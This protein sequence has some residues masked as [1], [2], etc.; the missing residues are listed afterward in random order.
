MT[1]SELTAW[2]VAAV[3][4]ITALVKLWYDYY[5]KPKIDEEAK[6]AEIEAEKELK[7]AELNRH[8][9]E[10]E[11]LVNHTL[12]AELRKYRRMVITNFQLEQATKCEVYKDL[13]VK[14]ID[15]W[16]ELLFELA[17]KID[18]VCNQECNGECEMV[19]PGV[20]AQWNAEVLD[21]GV[22]RYSTYYNSDEYTDQEKEL[23]AYAV[24]VFNP[25]HRPKI[26][27]VEGA[28][29]MCNEGFAFTKCTKA[30][31]YMIFTVYSSAFVLAFRDMQKVL[32]ASNGK[33]DG[34][35]FRRR[36]YLVAKPSFIIE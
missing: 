30:I 4:I 6:L 5:K 8:K 27:M 2:G 20:L 25:I 16:Q 15:I 18:A 11:K 9:K 13:L 3:S 29:S 24:S 23:C 34:K 33:F 14:K 1:V 19:S 31:Q 7:L 36:S 12:F 28:I 21:S 26:E 32:D 17:E 10:T 35:E 22:Q